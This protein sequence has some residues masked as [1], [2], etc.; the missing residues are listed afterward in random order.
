MKIKTA[1]NNKKT[2]VISKSEWLGIGKKAGF[3]QS[4]DPTSGDFMAETIKD[5]TFTIPGKA[6][7][8]MNKA[9]HDLG[10]YHNSFPL[11]QLF[12]A[13]E[14]NGGLLLQEDNTKWQGF[15]SAGNAECGSHEARKQTVTISIAIKVADPTYTSGSKY[16]VADNDLVI[17]WCKMSNSGR[18]EVVAYVS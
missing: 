12:Q 17:S 1:S 5:K 6:R 10:N 14:S 3:T 9:L 8:A 2:L 13:V 18:Y 11:Q 16:I 7:S 4:Q 15:F